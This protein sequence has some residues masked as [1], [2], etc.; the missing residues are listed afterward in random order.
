[1]PNEIKS[2]AKSVLEDLI[3]QIKSNPKEIEISLKQV[4]NIGE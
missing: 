2:D 4:L 3:K 1:L